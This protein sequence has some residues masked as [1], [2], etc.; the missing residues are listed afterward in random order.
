MIQFFQP[1]RHQN[2]SSEFVPPRAQYTLT[3]Q[4]LLEM[5]EKRAY[6]TFDHR[7]ST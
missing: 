1:E 2:N 5:D 3:P 6:R 4:T 7:K